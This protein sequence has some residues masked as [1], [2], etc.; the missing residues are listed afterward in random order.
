MLSA[1][2]RILAVSAVLA[3]FIY[4]IVEIWAFELLKEFVFIASLAVLGIAA[5][6]AH[7]AKVAEG[8]S[9]LDIFKSRFNTHDFLA[10]VLIAG[11]FF[12]PAYLLL[13]LTGI[14][15]ITGAIS[16]NVTF[17]VSY[18]I[19]S[20][21]LHGLAVGLIY[22][23][24]VQRNLRIVLGKRSVL[25]T[26][27]LFALAPILTDAVSN[28]LTSPK[29]YGIICFSSFMLMA[30]AVEAYERV[31]SIDIALSFFVSY[32]LLNWF[33]YRYLRVYSSDPVQS[34]AVFWIFAIIAYFSVK[35]IIQTPVIS[36]HKEKRLKKL[37]KK[38]KKK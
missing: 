22:I 2:S 10:G 35:Y 12:V 7:I 37:V 8:G 9:I 15:G 20:A 30:V 25:A 27:A 18:G 14:E 6:I 29:E 32:N 3:A 23:G 19:Y 26:S 13:N 31:R 34:Y 17:V 33:G 5:L 4:P 36:K 21:I 28:T 16:E 11:I 38:R 1:K 24:I